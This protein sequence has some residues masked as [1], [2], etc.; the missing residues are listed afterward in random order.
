MLFLSY[1]FICLSYRVHQFT[2]VEMFSV[3]TEDQSENVLESFKNIQLDLFKKLNLK[4]RLLDMPPMEL[5][6]PAYQKYD[7]EAWMPG[8]K[9]WGEISS[10]SNCTDYQAKRLNIRYI[11]DNNQ[12]RFAHTVNGTA[13]AIPRLLIGILETN[14]V[15]IHI[16]TFLFT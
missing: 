15:F 8:R 9:A 6:A 5:G 11:T 16:L 12:T 13:A 2:K 14:Q 1:V 3:C 4:F 7:I 10:C